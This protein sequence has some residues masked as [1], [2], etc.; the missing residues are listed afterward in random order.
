MS[1][2]A[3]VP[4]RAQGQHREHLFHFRD[5]GPAVWRRLRCEQ[6]RCACA[7]AC[8]GGGVCEA[9][10]ACERDLPRLRQDADD[11]PEWPARRPGC[12]PAATRAAPRQAPRPGNRGQRDRDGRVCRWRPCERRI[13][14]RRRWY[15]RLGAFARVRPQHFR[16]DAGHRLLLR[17]TC[18]RRG[19]RLSP[20]TFRHRGLVEGYYGPPTSH[21]ERKVWLER[22][23]SWGMNRYVVAAKD[24]PF[25]RARWRDPY[26]EREQAEIRELVEVGEAHSVDVGMALSPGLSVRYASPDDRRALVDKFQSLRG[27]GV[28][29]LSLQLDDV[30]SRLVDPK[31][32]ATFDSL[33]GAQVALM[34]ELAEAVPDVCWWLVP[35]EYQ[36]STATPYLETLG[37]E[38][39]T[40]I[41]VGWTGP[42]VLSPT[43]PAVDAEA[44]AATLRRP[45]LVWDNIPVADGPMRVL[46]HQ[47]PYTGREPALVTHLSGV[48]LNPME[49]A[50]ASALAVRTAAAWLDDPERY[51]PEAAWQAALRELG[52]GA[53][54]AYQ[55]FA[56]AHRWCIGCPDERDRELEAAF[57]RLRSDPAAPTSRANLRN[58][59]EARLGVADALRSNLADRALLTELDPWIDAH[60]TE[61]R[62]MLAALDLLDA[63]AGPAPAMA[64]CQAFIRFEGRLTRL[65]PTH[66]AS[67]GPSRAFV[68]QLTSMRD[69]E[70][71]FE[72]TSL[73]RDQNLAE[74][75]VRFA[76]ARAGALLGGSARD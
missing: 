7:D 28:R 39:D 29:F 31:D 37:R 36:G 35:T 74:E 22:L 57:D 23:G 15:T 46:L 64:W 42:S 43:I 72:P 19:R 70:A 13:D 69:E 9:G 45:L 18:R 14:P 20:S 51:E 53:P 4:A 65:P 60:H 34:H 59:L 71:G 16:S 24:D 61:T 76:E 38:L 33:A 25:Q 30:P 47:G 44:R 49:H 6:G 48:L 52:A 1:G 50:R 21:A 55:L 63:L 67:Y 10:P 32:V 12:V 58:H 40:R 54:A 27:L 68:P 56:E 11:G 26:P 75:I 41:E 62:R 66:L 73:T 8:F 5:F 17:Q 3:S 2:R